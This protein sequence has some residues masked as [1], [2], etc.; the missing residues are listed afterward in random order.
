MEGPSPELVVWMQQLRTQAASPNTLS[1][2]CSRGVV[3]RLPNF[4]QL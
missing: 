4:P 1:L 3:L 2:V